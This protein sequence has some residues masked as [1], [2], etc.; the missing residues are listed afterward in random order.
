MRVPPM[1]ITLAVILTLLSGCSSTFVG[2]KL[3]LTRDKQNPIVET[4][5]PVTMNRP[6]FRLTV[7]KEKV[8]NKEQLVSKIAVQWVPDNAQ[9]YTLSLDPGL[10]TKSSFTHTFDQAGNF[11]TGTG[12]VESQAV[13]AISTLGELAGLF[14]GLGIFDTTH[15]M[16]MLRE[17]IE[18]SVAPECMTIHQNDLFSSYPPIPDETVGTVIALRWKKYEQDGERL[19][20]GGSDA[21]VL[22]RIHFTSQQERECFATIRN[23][24]SEVKVAKLNALKVEFDALLDEFKSHHRDH[25]EFGNAS[26]EIERLRRDRNYEALTERYKQ[27]ND[28]TNPEYDGGEFGNY[29][30]LLLQRASPIARKE[31]SSEFSIVVLDAILHMRPSVWRARQALELSAR[32]ASAA[33]EGAL[34][35]RGPVRN[36][37]DDLV[38][39][40]N[41]ELDHIL[42]TSHT[43][44]QISHLEAY[45]AKEVPLVAGPNVERYAVNDRAKV[46]S[47][48]DALKAQH[49]AT[50]SLV[51][52]V[53]EAIRGPAN[54]VKLP[55]PEPCNCPSL[56]APTADLTL[57]RNLVIPT[58]DADFV[59]QTGDKLPE[60]P[61]PYVLVIESAKGLPKRM[62]AKQ[63]VAP[64]EG[65][66][67]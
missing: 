26:E 67:R 8:G 16:Q 17:E 43:T 23:T 66:E 41:A 15:P 38:K 48:L 6:E 57:V 42:G 13:T 64:A 28:E 1:L 44:T 58:A 31:E 5:I 20:K 22:E 60:N 45:L 14:F 54:R 34:Y 35:P 47:Q 9:R 39:E 61:P 37:Y 12:S 59:K 63:S 33:I 65:E 3:G 10:F 2:H 56:P 11:A 36:G 18:S 46:V 21:S 52:G 49:D 27:L 32:S 7:A 24:V 19:E 4:G 53:N 50:L 62:P 30:R 55:K 29:R 51:I 40:L 25:S